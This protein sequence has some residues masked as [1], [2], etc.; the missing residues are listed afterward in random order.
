[1]KEFLLSLRRDVTYE[2][3]LKGAGGEHVGQEIMTDQEGLIFVSQIRHEER[4]RQFCVWMSSITLPKS[5]N[6]AV[7]PRLGDIHNG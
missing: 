6:Y 5:F 7:A 3:Q 1:M 4:K 2:G